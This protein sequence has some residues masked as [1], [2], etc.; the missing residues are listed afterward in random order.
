MNIFNYIVVVCLWTRACLQLFLSR[1]G[2]R[3][4]AVHGRLWE[5]P[6]HAECKG[7]SCVVAEPPL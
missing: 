1:L 3:P 2:Q 7:E 4:K 5:H 6:Q